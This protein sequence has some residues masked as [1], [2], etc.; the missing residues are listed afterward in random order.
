[1]MHLI[2]Q[3]IINFYNF[4]IRTFTIF[5]SDKT[6]RRQFRAKHTILKK[7]YTQAPYREYKTKD[8]KGKIYY[9]YYLKSIS[10][11]K[12]KL[13]YE[14]YNKD[15]QRMKT[16]FIRG[17]IYAPI[18]PM[19]SASKYFIWDRYNPGQDVHFYTHEAVL[20]TIGN[21]KK[22]YAMF[23]EPE[24][25]APE[26]Y[27]VFDQNKGLEKD[28]DL[29]FTHHS[30]FLNKFDNARLFN[31]FARIWGKIEDKNGN[32]PENIMEYKTKN[33]SILSSD[34]IYCDLHKFRFELAN[35]CK[36]QALA[37]T[38]GTFDGG[39]FIPF[40]DTVL[41]Y[42]YSIVIENMIDEYWFTEKILNC[43]AYMCIPIYLG[44]S[45]IDSIFNPDG[46][47]KISLKDFDNIENILK[48]CTEENYIARINALKENYYKSLKYTST[49]DLLYETYLQ[50]ELD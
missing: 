41:N 40:S 42:K 8:G 16:F 10:P 12:L 29:I 6:K 25:I 38:Y 7:G 43:F 47:I 9:P 24:P 22:R 45:K 32:L 30:K 28:F 44:A 1:M 11:E 13:D 35:K 18:P 48:Q 50:K 34:K 23:A 14:I 21:P 49:S 27:T 15:G 2:I 3:F 37:D 39:N 36:K 31:P 46:I 5:I 26:S 19:A 33:V 20:E 17:P 4:L